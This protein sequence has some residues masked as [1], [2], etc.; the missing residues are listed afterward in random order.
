MT[1][2][3]LATR[4]LTDNSGSVT[5][6][7]AQSVW[8][9]GQGSTRQPFQW[10]GQQ[11]D[12]ETGFTFLRARSYLSS[13]CLRP[14]ISSGAV[15]A[16]TCPRVRPAKRW[17]RPSALPRAAGTLLGSMVAWTFNPLDTRRLTIREREV[18]RRVRAGDRNAEIAATLGVAVA[19]VE[20]PHA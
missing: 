9:T 15:C 5:H 13:I 2:T 12:P 8:G 3:G 11:F 19:T 18:L 20:Y 7:Y 14:R 10:T 17:S 6:T 4:A 16:A 1:R